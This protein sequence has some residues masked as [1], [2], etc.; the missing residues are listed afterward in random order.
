MIYL[1]NSIF[2]K[3]VKS[4]ADVIHQAGHNVVT[5]IGSMYST[6]RNIGSF[7]KYGIAAA[8]FGFIGYIAYKAL[9]PKKHPTVNVRILDDKRKKF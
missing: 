3:K 8:V 7:V 9:R 2:K 4:G 6:A 1:N 5:S